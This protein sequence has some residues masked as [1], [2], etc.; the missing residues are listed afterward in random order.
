MEKYVTASQATDNNTI[1]RMCFA[2]WIT[3]ATH[4]RS[5]YVILN[6]TDL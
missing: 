1:W 6:A 3:K 2:R 5:E 4:K